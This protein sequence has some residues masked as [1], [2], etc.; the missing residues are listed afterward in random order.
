MTML[1]RPAFVQSLL[2]RLIGETLDDI[3]PQNRE[4]GMA[5]IQ[6]RFPSFNGEDLRFMRQDE[7]AWARFQYACGSYLYTVRLLGGVFPLDPTVDADHGHPHEVVYAEAI[8]RWLEPAAAD[9]HVV[10]AY[11]RFLRW[12]VPLQ[13]LLLKFRKRRL[14]A[15]PYEVYLRTPYWEIV[16]GWAYYRAAGRCQLCNMP[17]SKI[18]LHVHHRT[19]DHLGEETQHPKDVIVLCKG[20]HER[21]HFPEGPG[22][23][24]RRVYH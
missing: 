13:A 11:V 12:A 1:V 10:F 14:C 18:P 2:F 16:R 19:Y 24:L 22:G 21:F 9:S 6:A 17:Q 20:C 3:D 7:E 4:A 23:T 8:C 15:L 5:A